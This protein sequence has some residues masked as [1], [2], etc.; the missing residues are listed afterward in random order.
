MP[1]ARLFHV[2]VD[3]Q[4]PEALAAFWAAALEVEVAGRW[5]QYVTLRPQREGDVALTF[6]QVPEPKSG[7]NRVH[8]D[9]RVDDLEAETAR[10]LA[11]GATLVSD[12]VEDGVAIRVLQDPEGNELCLVRY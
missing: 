4:D 7:K 10:L 8:V 12:D 9:L 11:L 2:V 1:S 3:C 5:H 6:Q